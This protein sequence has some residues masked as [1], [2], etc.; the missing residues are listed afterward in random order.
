ME[1][2]KLFGQRRGIEIREHIERLTGGPCP[3][4]VGLACPMKEPIV[5]AD[6]PRTPDLHVVA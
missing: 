1:C 5:V 4:K 3:C 2:E 6:E